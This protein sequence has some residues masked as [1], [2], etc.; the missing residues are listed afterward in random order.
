MLWERGAENLKG[1]YRSLSYRMPTNLQGY[2]R[3]MVRGIPAW[4]KDDNLYYYDMD[5]AKSPLIIGTVAEGFATNAVDICSEKVV[6]FR[7]GIESRSRSAA[8][9]AKKK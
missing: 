5:V 7:A 3:V 6:A 2:Q 1:V 4:K 8:T 9:P